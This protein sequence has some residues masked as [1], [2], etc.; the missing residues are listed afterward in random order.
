MADAPDPSEL[1]CRYLD[2][3]QQYLFQA[4]N[5]PE[6]AASLEKIAGAMPVLPGMAWPPMAGTGDGNAAEGTSTPAGTPDRGSDDIDEL[7]RRLADAEKRL[8]ALE[9][10]SRST[11]KRAAKESGKRKS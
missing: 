2:L 7:R 8:D 3:W 6:L 9:R 4:A 5:D 1:A 11:G 10:K